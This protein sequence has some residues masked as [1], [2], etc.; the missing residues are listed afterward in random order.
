[1]DSQ[2]IELRQDSAMILRARVLSSRKR[3]KEAQVSYGERKTSLEALQSEHDIAL[4]RLHELESGR[5]TLLGSEGPVKVYQF[6]LELPGY[7]GPING[8]LAQLDQHGS[9]QHVSD[10]SSKS[11]SGLVGGAAG[12]LLFGPLGGAA[13]V[14]ATRK[15]E[16][17]T[18]VR[19]VDSRQLEF[20]I[21][22]VGFA[23]SSVAH[24]SEIDKLRQ[25]RDLINSRSSN[26]EDIQTLKQKQLL[27]VEN[28]RK[29]MAD[30]SSG[31]VSAGRAMEQR[32]NAYDK[33]WAEYSIVRLSLFDELKFKWQCLPKSYQA[34]FILAGPVLFCVLNALLIYVLS[35]DTEYRTIVYMIAAGYCSIWV[36]A[37]AY[38]I[39]RYRF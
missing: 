21:S 28:F 16:V 19:K 11:K 10:V 30:V 14:L 22:G 6:W 18:N 24:Y 3:Y 4:T 27:L 17:K 12:W 15:N 39:A 1:M 36:G 31:L 32:K 35:A 2:D 25:L 20:L 5:G 37:L 26:S 8:V 33:V 7:S 23:W 13:G 34:I 29:K 38:Y 9:L